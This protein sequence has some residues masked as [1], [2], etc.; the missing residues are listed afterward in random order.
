[1]KKLILFSL[2]VLSNISYGQSFPGY[3]LDLL[4]GK[5]LRVKEKKESLQRFGYKDF[6]TDDSLK[7][8]YDCCETVDNTKYL[9]LAGKSFKMVS[10]EAY[11]DATGTTKFKLKVDN[12]ETGTIVYD[13]DPRFENSFAF[14]VIGGIVYPQEFYC[15]DIFFSVDKFSG[16]I[17]YS[18]PHG[19]IEFYKIIKGNSAR[20]QISLKV[21]GNQL[22]LNTKCVYILL[23][24]GFRIEKPDVKVNV[25]AVK[26]A[27]GYM[28]SAFFDLN[29]NDIKLL[30]AN[31]IT[32]YRLY[33][34]DDV[35]STGNKLME[36]LK[37]IAS[38]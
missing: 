13:Y 9:S 19:P 35:V 4:L 20:T 23:E 34:Y 11:N 33:I 18:T 17:S 6:Y 26:C 2:I 30:T 15:K 32:D 27:A 14:E 24:N 12:S 7:T 38:K 10:Y 3:N 31:K 36:Y 1:M 5:E 37:C 28:Y 22:V 29:E 25:S 8:N 16:E 21:Y